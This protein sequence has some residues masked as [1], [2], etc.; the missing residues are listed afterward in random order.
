MILT[1]RGTGDGET[2]L[3]WNVVAA[4]AFA[5]SCPNLIHFNSSPVQHVH[6][7]YRYMYVYGKGRRLRREVL[8]QT[9]LKDPSS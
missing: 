4:A 5:S 1:G 6:C 7:Y 8:H 2:G 9:A 3:F